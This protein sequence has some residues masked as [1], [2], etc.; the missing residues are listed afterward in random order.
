MW[1]SLVKIQ[2]TELK[3]SCGNDP[4]V[5]NS[6]YSNSDLDLWQQ[7]HFRTITL[8]LYI[9]SLTNLA[10]WFP[11]GRGRTLFILGSLGQRSRSLLLYIEFLT[12]G[13]FPHDNFSSVYWI[14]TKLGHM[15]PLWKGKNRASSLKQQSAD[16]HFVSIWHYLDSEPT[17]LCS[18]SLM[19]CA[20]WR[21]NNYQL[22][23]HWYNL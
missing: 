16:R 12:T 21:S 13:S 20:N 14:F 15:I 1:P 2:Y 11:C 9:G 17:S 3:L 6:I 4:V 18:F 7:G 19:R 22:Y 5:K 8:V 10:T 23:S